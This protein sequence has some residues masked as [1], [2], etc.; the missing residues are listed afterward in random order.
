M[1]PQ[2]GVW[3]LQNDLW[4]DNSHYSTVISITSQVRHLKKS[5]M[6]KNWKMLKKRYSEVLVNEK[7]CS[8][9]AFICMV[10]QTGAHGLHLRI[11]IGPYVDFHFVVLFCSQDEEE[12]EEQV[13]KF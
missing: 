12:N 4:H 5:W 7:F 1:T 6:I 9:S 10:S 13:S 3:A 2:I 8:S 11:L